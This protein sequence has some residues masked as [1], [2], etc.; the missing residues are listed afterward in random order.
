MYLPVMPSTEIAFRSMI[1]EEFLPLVG[2]AFVADCQPNEVEITLVEAS[3]LRDHGLADRPPFILI[4]YSPPEYML[5]DGTYVLRCGGWGPERISIWST[6]PPAKTQ[7]GY[8]YQAVF[9]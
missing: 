6:L 5:G 8:Y 3:P 7:P 1:L 9:N 4:F 2:K